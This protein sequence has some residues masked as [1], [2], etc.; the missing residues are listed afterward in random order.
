VMLHRAADEALSGLK[1]GTSMPSQ[2]RAEIDGY[3]A[4]ARGAEW[5][6]VRRE[7]RMI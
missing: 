1:P 2:A 3:V 4:L 5:P 7:C 6:I